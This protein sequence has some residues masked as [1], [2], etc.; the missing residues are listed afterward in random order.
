MFERELINIWQR[1][2]VHLRVIGE[3]EERIGQKGY[4]EL[5]QIVRDYEPVGLNEESIK[6]RLFYYK[7]WVC[8]G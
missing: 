5:L 7:C 4:P 6:E 3:N 8:H 1:H 2:S